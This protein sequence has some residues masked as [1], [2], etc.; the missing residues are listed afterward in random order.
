[1]AKQITQYTA[2][3]TGISAN[4]IIS[5]ASEIAARQNSATAINNTGEVVA[6]NRALLEAIH[7]TDHIVNVIS[8]SFTGGTNELAI[9]ANAITWWDQS[10]YTADKTATA[11]LTGWPAKTI[12][13]LTSSN[14]FYI[15]A[16]FVSGTKDYEAT[17]ITAALPS[18]ITEKN[19]IG[20]ATVSGAGAVTF[21][22]NWQGPTQ[23]RENYFRDA[24]Y[25][26]GGFSAGGLLNSLGRKNALINGNFDIWQRNTSF[27]TPASLAYTADR[28]LVVY[29]GTIGAF[30]I[31]R[32]AFSLGQSTVSNQPAFFYNWNHT[33]AG[34]GSTLRQIQQRIEKVETLN[35]Q[36][37]SLS[38]WAKADSARNIT[39]T[40]RQNFGT[41]GSPSSSVD[42][43]LGTFS[44]TTSWQKFTA[45]VTLP[46]VSG[47]TLGSANNDYLALILSLPINTI[48]SIDIAQVQLEAG[49][50]PT[51]F[52]LK[53]FITEWLACQ[54]Y[55]E[56]SFPY[57][58]APAQTSSAPGYLLLAMPTSLAPT[59]AVLYRQIKKAIPT[60][61]TYNPSAANA[62]WRN[63]TSGANLA[64]SIYYNSEIGAGIAASVGPATAALCAIHW[65]AE[66]EL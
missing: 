25:F 61:T 21:A 51:A 32:S 47:K 53:N 16:T 22:I 62:N 35:G 40:L 65:T 5:S 39:G 28:W 57:E 41:G 59:I 4:N 3:V 38:F 9:L 44:L 6:E 36:S 13:G 12:T 29:D 63:L 26:L 7:T 23:T 18:N 20:I 60:L 50:I 10:V 52:D 46:S 33:S 56:K 58:V 30:T 48:M 37:V 1:M 45:T 31:S 42:T 11:L 19:L 24:Q 27:T 8:T 2:N 14:T 15:W 34:S 54:R 17:N 55:Y 66:A 49:S 43:S 64:V